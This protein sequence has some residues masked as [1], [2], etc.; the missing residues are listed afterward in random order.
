MGVYSNNV[1]SIKTIF[2]QIGVAGLQR[3]IK[4]IKRDLRGYN[5][6][7]ANQSQILGASIQARQ[8]EALA[9]QTIG[10]SVESFGK[11]FSESRSNVISSGRKAADGIVKEQ[12]AIREQSQILADNI[13]VRQK[14]NA[15][16]NT[17]SRNIGVFDSK[18]DSARREG[19]KFKMEY[20]GVMFAGMAL[21]RAMV[22]LNATSREW[23]GI[24]ELTSTM[25]G[26]TM[27]GANTDLL[28]FG[29]LPLF[30]ALINLPPKA[31]KSIGYTT[32]ALEGL[33]DVLLVGGQLAL[34]AYSLLL[35]LQNM[36][37]PGG[38]VAG[39]VKSLKFL[40]GTFL[41]GTSIILAI[42]AITSEGGKSVLYTIGAALSAGLA[43][44]W[45][46]TG[47]VGIIVGGIVLTAL[48]GIKMVLD[49]IEYEKDLQNRMKDELFNTATPMEQVLRGFSPTGGQGTMVNFPKDFK[50]IPPKDFR[51]N[52]GYV[53]DVTP[54]GFIGPTRRRIEDVTPGGF[55]MNV[56]YNLNGSGDENIKKIFNESNQSLVREIQRGVKL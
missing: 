30:D 25:M 26:I 32:F 27:L 28:V 53:E 2:E 52:T 3:T 11:K 19:Q 40:G 5:E 55:S 48:F 54:G 35:M 22:N 31:Q 51:L 8:K 17:S 37:G 18:L 50:W 43:A 15:V 10:Q 39:L 29:V 45:F 42:S 49:Q 38:A 6:I 20:L 46:T 23:L 13:A 7:T 4:N 12:S 44:A 14:G 56:T 47:P 21:N 9:Y 41:I 33:G 36:G 1:I 34:G 16:I 24:G